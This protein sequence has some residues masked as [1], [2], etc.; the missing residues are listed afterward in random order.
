[1]LDQVVA[2]MRADLLKLR[3]TLGEVQFDCNQILSWMSLHCDCAFLLLAVI[4]DRVVFYE[5]VLTGVLLREVHLAVSI[6]LQVLAAR[7][8]MQKR[9]DLAAAD[10]ATR[11]RR[12]EAAADAGAEDHMLRA[13]IRRRRAS[14]VGAASTVRTLCKPG[15]TADAANISHQVHCRTAV[16]SFSTCLRSCRRTHWTSCGCS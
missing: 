2:D 13:A 16:R 12:A 9:V 15:S 8:L 6:F 10:L 1:M 3:R 5:F 4:S 14:Q 7:N 11:T